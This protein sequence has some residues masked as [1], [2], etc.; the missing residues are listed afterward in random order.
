VA[1]ASIL[2][3]I[4]PAAWAQ[5]RESGK[6]TAGAAASAPASGAR[7]V[8]VTVYNENLGVVKD[9][10]RFSIASGL[11]ELRFTDVASLIEPTSVLLR[12]LGKSPLETL[13]QDSRFDLV[14]TDK[15]LERYVAQPIEVSTKDDQVK[16]G[17]LLS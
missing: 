9:R 6:A 5:P 8:A 12:S 1:A 11:T 10:R 15:L 14:S 17:T 2:L 4:A 13:W 16:R 3:G 7:E